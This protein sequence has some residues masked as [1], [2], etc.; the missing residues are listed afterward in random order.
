MTSGNRTAEL[1]SELTIS[2]PAN[3]VDRPDPCGQRSC[4]Q[5]GGC[6]DERVGCALRARPPAFLVNVVASSLSAQ[7]L[8]DG[9]ADFADER[10]VFPVPAEA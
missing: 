4:R 5:L 7:G 6:I 3:A 8:F 1:E 2:A 9:R 10:V